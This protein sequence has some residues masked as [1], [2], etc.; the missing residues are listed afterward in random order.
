MLRG[1]IVQCQWLERKE[2]AEKRNKEGNTR[3][4]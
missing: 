3:E 2:K 1:D 4:S